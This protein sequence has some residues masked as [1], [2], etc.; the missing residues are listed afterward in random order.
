MS[1]LPPIIEQF[2]VQLCSE[3]FLRRLEEG[4]GPDG[5]FDVILKASGGKAVKRPCFVLP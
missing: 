2:I 4:P 5:Q 1:L 3:S